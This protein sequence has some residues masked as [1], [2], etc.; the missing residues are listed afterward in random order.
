MC[1][2]NKN[3]GLDFKVQTYVFIYEVTTFVYRFHYIYVPISLQKC[4]VFTTK[5]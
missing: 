1:E 4:T 3:V 2:V 5:V